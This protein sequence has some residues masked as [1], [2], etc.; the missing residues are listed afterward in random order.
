MRERER[1]SEGRREQG[2]NGV[3]WPKD[4]AIKCTAGVE[5]LY[6]EH[7]VISDHIKRPL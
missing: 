4:A 6:G 1:E 7:K 2:T 5:A 3:K